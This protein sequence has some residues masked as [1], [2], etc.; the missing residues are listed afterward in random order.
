MKFLTKLLL[1]AG[2]INT[3]VAC[4]FG[5][6]RICG[7]QTPMAY[8]NKESY[9][10]LYHPK[11]YGEHWTKPSMTKESWREDWVACGG[12]SNGQYSG[13]APEGSTTQVMLEY[14]TK[15]R[16]KL[17]TCMQSKGYEYHYTGIGES[18]K[19]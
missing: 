15:E 19:Q 7:P 6:G 3:L 9:E 1:V 12:M 14:Q 13:G 8:C 16:K 17:D 4:T 18:P 11:A 2:A 5:N 10:K